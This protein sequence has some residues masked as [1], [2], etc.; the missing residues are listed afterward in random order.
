MRE[1][2]GVVAGLAW[3]RKKKE[4]KR[5]GTKNVEEFRAV[6]GRNVAEVGHHYA[7]GCEWNERRKGVQGLSVASRPMKQ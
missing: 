1:N 5:V 4:G 3:N 6:H 2:D 7:G